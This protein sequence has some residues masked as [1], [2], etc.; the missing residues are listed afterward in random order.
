MSGSGGP[1]GGGGAGG[2]DD[3]DRPVRGPR[4]PS[5][6]AQIPEID[7]IMR[8]GSERLKVLMGGRGGGGRGAGGEQ[9]GLP[10]GT[11]AFAA[12]AALAL[13]S[14]ESFYTVRPEER[15]VELFL[16]KC[17]S[18][19]IGEPGLNFAPWPVVIPEKV[20]LTTERTEDIGVGRGGAD[21][22]GLMLTGDENIV[23]IDFQ[24]V[25]NVSDPEKFLFNLRDPEL[26]INAV[27]E[28]SMREIIA[29]S[30]LAPILNRD[31][32]AI[33]ER[34]KDLIQTTLDSYNSGLNVVRVNFDRADPPREVIEAFKNVQS[35]EQERDR[36]QKEADAYANTVVAGARGQAAQILEEAEA[37]RAQVV[38]QAEGEASRFSAVL[39]EYQKAPE[40]TRKRLYL[41]T[42]EEVM[43][44]VDKVII[45]ES[46]S[47]Q[48]V[49]PYLP[50]N[51]LGRKP[52][53][54]GN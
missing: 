32:G 10:R 7:D 36:L 22:S 54:E 43:G 17:N 25:W 23:D 39:A 48:G 16:G 26:T 40:V 49:V 14:Y 21:D 45:D 8:K 1:W 20:Q 30:Q 38:N 46:Q 3:D 41:E 11:F 35:A 6:G 42:M 2:G 5:G 13:W 37:Y 31:R 12:L 33:A 18:P 15:S 9:P 19:C 47:G 24:V 44:R 52:A 53:A 34:L 28:A 29:Q 27:A 51:E 50:L 4:R